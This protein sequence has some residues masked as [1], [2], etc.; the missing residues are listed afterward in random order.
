LLRQRPDA[1]EQFRAAAKACPVNFH[2]YEGAA[3][4]LRAMG[5][6]LV[7]PGPTVEAA[8]AAAAAASAASASSSATR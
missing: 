7:Q 5:Q 4:E 8:R 1:V 3:A 6:S 2:E